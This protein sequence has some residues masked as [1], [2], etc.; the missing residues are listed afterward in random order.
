MGILRCLVNHGIDACA[1][2]TGPDYIDTSFLKMASG[3]D[4]GNLDMFLQGKKGIRQALSLSHSEYA[5][6]EGVMGYFDGIYNTFENS[7]YDI[8]KELNI[9]SVLV[10]TPEGEM[11]TAIP[12]IKGMAEFPGSGIKCVILNN[13][14]ESYYKL[15]KEQIEKFTGVRVLGYLPKDENFA[16]ES[17]H[18]GLIQCEEIE[19]IDEIIDKIAEKVSRYIDI[20][21]IINLMKEVNTEEFPHVSK[22]DLKISVASDKA[23]SFY[24]R[25]NIK[26]ISDACSVNYFSPLKDEKVPECD[27]LYIG[28]G[29]PEVF[30]EEL[31]ENTSMLSSVKQYSKSGG[32]IYAECGGLMYLLNDIEGF[33]MSG[34]L[35]GK[36]T[37]TDR[38]QHFGYA[39]IEL[40]KDCLLGKRGDHLKGQ[41]FHKSVSQVN[42]DTVYNV[43]SPMTDYYWN[44]GYEFNNAF[45]AYAHINFLGNM[46]AFNSIINRAVQQKGIK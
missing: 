33:K 8:A 40:K 17:R 16:L 36:S 10:Y 37:I 31:S 35:D 39:D 4:A 34:V 11:F 7:S 28:G 1:F 18:L 5:V 9:N 12:K 26:L 43:K 25:E 30:K 27:I 20:N 13:V 19:K 2:K 32:I 22:T 15:L 42:L 23:F 21:A 3:K 45:A 41:E 24:Y 46:T 6:I 44:C 29:Y 14:S 38:L